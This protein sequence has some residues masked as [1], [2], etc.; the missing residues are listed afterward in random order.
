MPASVVLYSVPLMLTSRGWWF[1]LLALALT[2]GA[3]LLSPRGHV[4]LEVIGL[5]L[6]SWFFGQWLLFVVQARRVLHELQVERQLRDQRGPVQNL[7]A[8][9][10]YEVCVRLSLPGFLGLPHVRLK[11]RM[12]AGL[13]KVDGEVEW[14][15]RLAPG[16]P[17]E[18]RYRVHCP[19][20]GRARFE[21]VRVQMADWQGFFYHTAF[22]SA[23]RAYR[24]LPMLVDAE[25]RGPTTKRHN[26]LP[27]PGIHHLRQPGSGSELLDL[28]DYL[29][30]DPP[31]TIAWKVS[32]R[33]GRLITKEFESEVPVR[34]TLFVDASN[35]VRLGPPGRN[36]LARQVEIAAAVAQTTVAASDLIG[37]CVFD[38]E[39]T[40]CLRPARTPRHLAR[41][42]NVLAD[43]A[44]RAPTQG[45]VRPDALLP[46]AHAF[47]QEVYPQLLR[48]E[49]NA[50]PFWLPWLFPRSPFTIR[51]PTVGDYFHRALPFFLVLYAIL[52]SGVL[53]AV[54]G[55]FVF[56][57]F[58]LT[59]S[60][61]G[62]AGWPLG[63][64]FFFLELSIGII[65]ANRVG[66][67]FY[68]RR[69]RFYRWRKQLAAILSVRHGLLPGGLGMLLED[70]EQFAVHC[71]RFLAEHQVPYELPL[72][73]RHGRYLFA[74]PEKIE[75]LA[76][77]LLRA[78]RWSHDNELFVLL[79]DLLEV[80]DALG[81]LLRAVHVA[82]ARHHQVLLVCSW[83]PG[84]EPP[85]AN[86]KLPEPLQAT[87][88]AAVP[89]TRLLD[90]ATT[91]RFHES[92]FRLRRTF[93]RLGVPVLCARGD[94]PVPLI[95][96]RLDRLRTARSRPG[97]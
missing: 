38:E 83:P 64:L 9:R 19:G 36:A 77:A 20:V 82:R 50:F 37:L 43:T 59:R 13:E 30:G 40:D 89:L 15:G 79:A 28:R 75:V 58:N 93:A 2:T 52:A 74:A 54:A 57:W 51:E 63:C 85:P 17:A 97:R 24:V 21:G 91:L 70:D 69:R 62:E 26:L 5:T 16:R 76:G 86:A 95:V 25:G 18:L 84:M 35:S 66:R 49:I 56:L 39:T 11:D 41:L 73:D 94:E 29:P 1:F 48:P 14:E 4:T 90:R 87:A 47:A 12:P 7:W 10:T 3:I 72:Y 81:P 8:G 45:K 92:F 23:P 55:L 53:A 60:F 31:R 42:L 80:P 33:R 65:L 96:D 68:P 67:T 71:Q 44:G 27:P 78:V 22:A 32:A 46:L 6:L 34:C 61:G 88:D